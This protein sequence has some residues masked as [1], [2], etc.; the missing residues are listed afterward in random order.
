[1][2]REKL[3]KRLLTLIDRALMSPLVPRAD[4]A[5]LVALRVVSGE[6]VADAALDEML[7]EMEKR[8]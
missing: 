7:L 8:G 1:M 6:P 3:R 5:I 4:K 2:D